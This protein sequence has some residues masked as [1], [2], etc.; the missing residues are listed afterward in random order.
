MVKQAVEHMS[1]VPD[2]RVDELGVERRVLVGDSRQIRTQAET[3]SMT[4]SMPKANSRRLCATIPA[5]IATAVSTIIQ[6][7]VSHSNRNAR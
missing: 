6:M 1:C 5:L 3:I 2:R 4:L 7:I